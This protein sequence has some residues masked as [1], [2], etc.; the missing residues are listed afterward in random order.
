MA[1]LI[2]L[3]DLGASEVP[4]VRPIDA[5]PIMR[6]AGTNGRREERTPD[7]RL[8]IDLVHVA[9]RRMFEA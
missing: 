2:A 6:P 8:L 9:V 1:S 4:L 5:R 7:D 3:G